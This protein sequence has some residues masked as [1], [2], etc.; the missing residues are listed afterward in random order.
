MRSEDGGSNVN[1]MKQRS[2]RFHLDAIIKIDNIYVSDK[3]TS[4]QVKLYQAKILKEEVEE[5]EEWLL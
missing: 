5:P 4:I 3:M 2:E 1:P